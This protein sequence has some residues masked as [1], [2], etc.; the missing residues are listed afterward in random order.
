MAAAAGG[1]RG[2][3]AGAAGNDPGARPAA[4]ALA[5]R[6]AGAS[7]RRAGAA[8]CGNGRGQHGGLGGRAMCGGGFRGNPASPAVFESPRE[9]GGPGQRGRKL[10]SWLRAHWRVRAGPGPWG[11]RLVAPEPGRILGVR[12][13]VVPCSAALSA[14]SPSRLA[15]LGL[16]A[17]GVLGG[18]GRSSP[19]LARVPPCSVLAGSRTGESEKE[20][21]P[22][23][24]GSRQTPGPGP[25]VLV[26]PLQRARPLG[27][28][29]STITLPL[30][31]KRGSHLGGARC[32]SWEALG[33]FFFL[34]YLR[35]LP[36]TSECCYF[37]KGCPGNIYRPSHP[38]QSSFQILIKSWCS[39]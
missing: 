31:Q 22:E 12:A 21:V 28:Q 29:A 32:R 20:K 24:P 23:R 8:C 14:R 5:G 36:T 16:A 25:S 6:A 10:G 37:M 39:V 34:F 19:P 30:G 7:G 4:A 1:L 38:F 17:P 35:P 9:L 11:G 13:R 2:A 26:L 33:G 3:A 27:P 18:A 15:A